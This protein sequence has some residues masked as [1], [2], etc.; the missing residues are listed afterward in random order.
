MQQD[1]HP[2]HNAGIIKKYLARMKVKALPWPPSSP[3]LA[4]IE[5]LWKQDKKII[6]GL[7]HC[8]R[9][10]EEIGKEIIKAWPLI[11]RDRVEKLARS[12]HKRMDLF[13]KAKGGPIKY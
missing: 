6:S 8:I 10:E 4:P 5:N 9:T 3:D 11:D 12:L 7:R 1:N 2:V 13:I